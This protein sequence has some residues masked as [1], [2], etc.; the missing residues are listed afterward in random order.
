MPYGLAAYHEKK[1][2]EKAQT[3]A[4]Q[5]PY[6]EEQI[7]EIHIPKN[8]L[9]QSIK[10]ATTKRLQINQ[11]DDI[12]RIRR[13]IYDYEL[14]LFKNTERNKDLKRIINKLNKQI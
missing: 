12:D 11:N 13:L 6:E 5:E 2:L 7:D 3:T 8:N 4:E 10:K 14:E 9:R 1:R